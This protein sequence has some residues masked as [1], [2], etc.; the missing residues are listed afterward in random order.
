MSS[1]TQTLNLHCFIILFTSSLSSSNLSNQRTGITFPSYGTQAD[2]LNNYTRQRAGNT[3][4][5][6]LSNISIAHPLFSNNGQSNATVENYKNKEIVLKERTMKETNEEFKQTKINPELKTQISLGDSG[7]NYNIDEYPGNAKYT[8]NT[9]SDIL[10]T[11]EEA[12][13][14]GATSVHRNEAKTS[15]PIEEDK[16]DAESALSGFYTECLLHLSFSCIQRKLLVYVDRLDRMKDFDVIGDY[17]SVVRLGKTSRR[18][19]MTEENLTE[20]KMST[21]DS[22]RKLDS[23]LDYSIKRFLYNHAI[24]VKVPSWVSVGV[25]GYQMT[26][27]HNTVNFSLSRTGIEEGKSNFLT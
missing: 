25:T 13:N 19:L 11:D 12:M 2:A 27:P 26:S 10:E 18:P 7:T 21:D 6:A 20:P 23:L 1:H 22:I 17:L 9:T 24:R 4:F 8:I 14:L 15:S 16:N 5:Q 3:A